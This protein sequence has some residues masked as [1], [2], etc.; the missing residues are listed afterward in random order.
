MAE[1]EN[2]TEENVPPPIETD[3]EPESDLIDRYE[4][5]V[6][7]QVETLNG[8]DDK[9]ATTM[10]VVAL[11][12]GVLLTVLT[13]ILDVDG[14]TLSRESG[15]AILWLA[16]GLCSLLFSLG[17]SVYT[18]LSSRFLHGPSEDLGRV[19]AE[20]HVEVE[21]YRSHLLRGYATAIEQNRHVVRTNS[22]RFRNCLLALM[23]GILGVSLGLALLVISIP[24]WGE[25]VVTIVVSLVTG[26]LSV[27]FTREGYLTL[28]HNE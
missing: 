11:L 10:R 23:Y 18:Y 15:L 13:L 3:F 4:R 9:A 5:M 8:I 27:H 14:I 24:F 20:H 26:G 2:G 1:K 25:I 6:Q 17:F 16:I 28:P 12:L 22:R 21:D 7:T 19:L